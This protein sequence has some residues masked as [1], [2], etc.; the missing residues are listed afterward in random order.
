MVPSEE[1]L[2]HA[3]ECAYMAKFSHD[4]NNKRVWSRMAERWTRC[5]ELARELI[6]RPAA[7]ERCGG[8]PRRA[9]RRTNWHGS[10][11]PRSCSPGGAQRNPETPLPRHD[12]PDRSARPG[13][14]HRLNAEPALGCR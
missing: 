8:G 4:P 1:F 5:A 13:D 3:T 9:S 2:R 14:D 7:G 12:A 11:S 10:R 6:R